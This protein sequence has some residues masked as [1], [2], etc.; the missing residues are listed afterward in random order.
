M[1]IVKN[2]LLSP[3][4][5]GEA[6][7]TGAGA[8][9][10]SGGGTGAGAGDGAGGQGAGAGGNGQGT[11][12]GGVQP[13]WPADWRAQMAGGDEKALKQLERY[14]TPTD[15]YNKARSLE[16]RLS[17]GELKANVPFPDKGTPEEQ[18]KWRAEHGIPEAPDKYDLK[19]KEGVVLGDADK[20]VVDKFLG[21]MHGKNLPPSVA[22]D[23]V[24]WYFDEIQAQNEAQFQKDNELKQA[25]EDKMRAE[26]G[27]EFR[28]NLNAIKNLTNL[29]GANLF[30]A[31]SQARMADGTP[32]GSSPE[33]MKWLSMVA[34]QINPTSTLVPL[35]GANIQQSVEDEIKQIET[36]MRTN[37]AEYNRDVGKQER[38]RALYEFR[39]NNSGKTAA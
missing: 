31:I 27:N 20:A 17:S 25:F 5:A 4:N 1:N 23:V 32:F 11:G 2:K 21:V 29:G 37:R 15:I 26:W 14:N 35:D 13:T 12:A 33:V 3:E 10:G 38:L 6:G 16:Q 7:A 30:D 39:A 34:R 36:F 19:L 8:G 22:S 24:N 9:A 18:T 28:P